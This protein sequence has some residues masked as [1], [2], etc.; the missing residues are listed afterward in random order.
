MP[1]ASGSVP[2]P[3]TPTPTAWR[4][5]SSPTAR[6]GSSTTS[7]TS[8]GFHARRWAANFE[9][10]CEEMWGWTPS[11]FV[12][13]LAPDHDDITAVADSG[14]CAEE[15]AVLEEAIAGRH[16]ILRVDRIELSKN[17]QRGFYAYDELLRTRPEWRRPV[18]FGA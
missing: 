18:V 17:L 3:S 12:S 15:S 14:A 9:S 7:Y 1:K 4:M 10:C 13:P 6:S 8:C 2:W 16:F 11:T 5:T